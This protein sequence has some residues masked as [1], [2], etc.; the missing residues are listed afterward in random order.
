MVQ[1]VTPRVKRCCL[2]CGSGF[3]PASSGHFKHCS[4]L[5]YATHR[6]NYHTKLQRESRIR[7][8]VAMPLTKRQRVRAA[9]NRAERLKTE[10]AQILSEGLRP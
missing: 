9:K 8:R 7:K 6:R 4:D 1:G 2:E 3:T 5:C 10:I